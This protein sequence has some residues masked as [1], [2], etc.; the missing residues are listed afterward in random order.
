MRSSS[1]A[2]A[3]LN[4]ACEEPVERYRSARRAATAGRCSQ[5]RASSDGRQVGRR[6]A[7]GDRA[8]DG[9]AVADLDVA[10][11]LTASATQAS[12]VR[13]RVAAPRTSSARRSRSRRR[14]SRRC[15]GARR[16]GRCRRAC[17]AL[18]EPQLEQRQEAHAAGDDLGVAAS[19][20][21][22][23]RLVERGRRAG[24]SNA[25]G[26]MPGLPSRD[27]IARHT[28]CAV[29]GM[30][31]CR[32]PSGPSASHDGVGHRRGA[33]DGTRPRRRP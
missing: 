32:M 20:R 28:V 4:G 13:R 3:G 16:A 2:D 19:R 22:P 31:R 27:W 33:R 26:I 23:Q 1:G 8:A 18:G 5:S 25:A 24:S 14:Q 30:S 29:Y 6:V 11:A 15:P 21:W 7:V 17:P 10:D 9:A 12:S